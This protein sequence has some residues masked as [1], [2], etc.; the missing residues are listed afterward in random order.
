MAKVAAFR[1][2]YP[3]MV[4]SSESLV[5][6]DN[7]V[8]SSFVGSPKKMPTSMLCY[9]PCDFPCVHDHCIK[10]GGPWQEGLIEGASDFEDESVADHCESIIRSSL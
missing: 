6:R 9:Q 5:Q 2:P 1:M 8:F 4:A 3:Q 10:V 7:G